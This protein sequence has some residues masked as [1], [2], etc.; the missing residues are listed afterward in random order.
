MAQVLEVTSP[1]F[2]ETVLEASLERPV[3]VD[4]YAQWCGPCQ[5]LKPLLEDL[6]AEYDF[7]LAKVDIDQNP[8]LAR[9][10]QVQGVPDVKVAVQGQLQSGF[11]GMLPEPQLREWLQTLGLQSGLT[12]S[13][14][15]A[16]A[17]AQA[18]DTATAASQYLAL[19]EQYPQRPEVTL[20]AARFYSSQGQIDQAKTLL[21]AIDPLDRPYG[22][23]AQALK[24]LLDFHQVA[25]TL[26][27]PTPAEQLYHDG[28]T[29]A[30]AQDYDAALA[31][32]L[33]LVT[34]DRA[35]G[36]DAGRR[37]LLTLFGVLGEEDARTPAYRKRL[38]QALY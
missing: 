5:M 20:A 27:P 11:V 13:L 18:G 6:A 34:C 10:Y 17:A 14:A 37:A 23:Q 31:K 9:I 4:F 12:R 36:N 28:V 24:A 15:A 7:T 21:A 16:T 19:L 3:V 22:D 38:M 8:E 2:E 35:Y 30:I 1:T 29:A 26:V 25:A 32:F 33:E